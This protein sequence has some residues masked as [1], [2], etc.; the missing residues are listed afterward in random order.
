MRIIIAG[1]GT[2]G[3]VFPA[4]SIAE[5]ITDRNHEDEILFVWTE[6]GL[7]NELLFKKG[8]KIKHIR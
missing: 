1:G 5:E 7:E 4:V 3:H 8:Y 2:G 6:K